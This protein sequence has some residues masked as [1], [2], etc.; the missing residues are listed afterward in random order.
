MEI[1]NSSG[2]G[3]SNIDLQKGQ[4]Q[5]ARDNENSSRDVINGDNEKFQEQEAPLKNTDNAFVQVNEDGSPLFPN[6]RNPGEFEDEGS[7]GEHR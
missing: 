2:V 4:I 7:R 5:N 3:Q 1:R 6:E